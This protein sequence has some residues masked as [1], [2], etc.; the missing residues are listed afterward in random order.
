MI[1]EIETRFFCLIKRGIRYILSVVGDGCFDRNA[2]GNSK[3]KEKKEDRIQMGGA[4]VKI[5]SGAMKIT[6]LFLFFPYFF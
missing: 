1:R 3:T 4:G 5:I 6:M 2:N